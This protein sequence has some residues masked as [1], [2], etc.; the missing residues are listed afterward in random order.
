MEKPAQFTEVA[1]NFPSSETKKNST[2]GKYIQPLGKANVVK[3]LKF[4]NV[5]CTLGWP[6]NKEGFFK[7]LS[8]FIYTLK[9][10]FFS[11]WV[12]VT[13][14]VYKPEINCTF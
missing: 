4:S 13:I 10:F 6:F 9:F 14:R 11:P 7:E 3:A 12:D 8:D 1:F 5:N 2:L